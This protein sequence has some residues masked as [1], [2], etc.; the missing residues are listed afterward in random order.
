MASPTIL[1]V[2]SVVVS[3][4]GG[5]TGDNLNDIVRLFNQASSTGSLSVTT[6]TGGQTDPTLP[7]PTDTTPGHTKVLI[8]PSSDTGTIS[9]PS[10]YDFYIYNGTGS[11]VGGVPGGGIIGDLNYAG[12][13]STVIATGGTGTV[14]D[15]VAGAILSFFAGNYTANGT[16]NGQAFD[17]DSAAQFTATVGG[18]NSTVLVGTPATAGGGAV[19]TVQQNENFLTMNGTNDVVSVVA[20]NNFI[21]E[22]PGVAGGGEVL[23]V[24]GGNTILD[25]SAS[26]AINQTTGALVV[27]VLAG[28]TGP[29]TYTGTGGTAIIYDAVGGSMITAGQSTEFVG[30]PFGGTASTL[31]GTGGADTIFAGA[32]M[33]YQGSSAG[34]SS[35]FFAGGSGAVTVTGATTNTIYGATAPGQY[36]MGSG[37]FLFVGGGATDTITEDSVQSA[38]SQIWTSN[39]ENLTVTGS[40]GGAN[41]VEFGSGA[42]INAASA[43]GGNTFAVYNL[44]GFSGDSTL[45]GSNAGNDGFAMFVDS[46]STAPH[47]V[48][49]DNWQASDNMFFTNLT[50]GASGMP[51]ADVTTLTAFAAGSAQSFTLADGTTVVF[52]QGRPA[53]GHMF[54]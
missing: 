27:N 39:N 2:G 30:N 52:D 5:T 8:I 42:M 37:V 26:T 47:T 17:F 31:V 35:L 3:V 51:A 1:S 14:T 49:I 45:V 50:Q 46:T 54:F 10:G 6:V 18:N 28:S 15:S 25:M 40:V 41:Y 21:Y 9:I 53:A 33:D 38:F 32:S 20:A 44:A 48:H 24:M 34:G 29:L 4:T 7:A 43:G 11:V 23:S 16:G 36:S 13:A 12:G 22:T 19:Q